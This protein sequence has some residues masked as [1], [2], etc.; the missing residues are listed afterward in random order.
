MQI[1]PTDTS[2]GFISVSYLIRFRGRNLRICSFTKHT[3]LVTSERVKAAS[4]QNGWEINE[5]KR[6]KSC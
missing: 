6:K 5:G 1:K 2:K 3:R 4:R